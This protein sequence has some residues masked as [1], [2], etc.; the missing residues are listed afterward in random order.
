MIILFYIH[1]YDIELH[2]TIRNPELSVEL[3]YGV[4]IVLYHLKECSHLHSPSFGFMED[5]FCNRINPGSK[6]SEIFL[7]LRRFYRENLQFDE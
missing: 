4:E 5:G 3:L 6:L 7:Y 1:S 2:Y